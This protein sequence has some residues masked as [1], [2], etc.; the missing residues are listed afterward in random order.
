MAPF[1]HG[2]ARHVA[3]ALGATA[4]Q[5]WRP[6]P[7]PHFGHLIGC[8]TSRW[9]LPTLEVALWMANPKLG[10]S[11]LRRRCLRPRGMP[12]CTHPWSRAKQ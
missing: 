9:L 1:L 6:S 3:E 12:G 8:L 7:T 10:A 4:W 2:W 5:Q 11:R